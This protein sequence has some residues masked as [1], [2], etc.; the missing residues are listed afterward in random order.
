MKTI[1]EERIVAI[2]GLLCFS[3]ILMYDFVTT[4]TYSQPV[5]YNASSEESDTLELEVVEENQIEVVSRTYNDDTI[6]QDVEESVVVLVNINTATVEELTT[7]NGI[8]DSIANKIVS[9][10]LEYGEF[11]TIEAITDVSGIAESKFENIREHI[12]V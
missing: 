12:T 8:G 9:H 2:V 7:L 11:A 10:R 5:Y 1:K 3:F 6:V 4:P